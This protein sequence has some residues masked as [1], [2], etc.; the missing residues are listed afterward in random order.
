VTESAETNRAT[1]AW[2]QP[3]S[4][5]AG[6]MALGAL[7]DAGADLGYVIST[8]EGLG[9]SGWSLDSEQTQ[10]HSLAA[11]RALVDAPEQHHHRKWSDISELLED[12]DL[13][14]RVRD[15]AHRIFEAL[16]IAEA[17]VHGV[18]P[19]EVH[20]HEVGALDAIVDIVGCCAALESLGIDIVASAPVAVGTGT[21][22][23]AH[24]VLPNP[25]PAVVRLLKGV[26][27][28]GIDIGL[29]LT[30]PTGAAI[31]S[32]LAETLGPMP[33]MTIQSSG[34]GAGTRDTPDRA[35]VT[36]VVIGS[37]GP[38]AMVTDNTNVEE[39]T[40]LSTNIDDITGELLA[41]A[42]SELLSAG[43]LDVWAVPIVMKK[44]RPA[45]SLNI[46]ARQEMVA[47]LTELLFGLT[48]TLGVRATTVQR[49]FQPRSVVEVEVDGQKISVKVGPAR[50]KAEFDDVANAART[51]GRSPA[52]VATSAEALARHQVDN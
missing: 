12:S 47:E 1:I 5:I 2:F 34:F 25:P 18:E 16:A 41:H 4:G 19:D 50:L 8:L 15:R 44:G 27:T 42:I 20:F 14:D 43:A 24:G 38:S 32:A 45:H 22:T 11:T 6:D 13:P 37:A 36:H 10:R 48:G 30:T 35:N 46:L 29:E 40:E 52:D 17:Q 51:L 31:V 7:L 33:S 21:I 3:F 23:A 26:P 9:I 28:I 49:T 39:L